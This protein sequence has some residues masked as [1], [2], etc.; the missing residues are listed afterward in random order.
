MIGNSICFGC[1]R[2]TR[3]DATHPKAYCAAFPGG[4][5]DAILFNGF[6]HRQPYPLDNGIRFELADKAK[7][8]GYEAIA[9]I[10]KA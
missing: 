2:F 10:T 5:P 9:E 8:D 1:T 3:F 7:L 6:D 4:I